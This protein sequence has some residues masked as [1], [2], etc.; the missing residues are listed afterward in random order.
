MSSILSHFPAP[1]FAVFTPYFPEATSL[2]PLLLDLFFAL[3]A[4]PG[5]AK[6]LDSTSLPVAGQVLPT[7]EKLSRQA[8][9]P[10][11]GNYFDDLPSISSEP[12]SWAATLH[13]EPSCGAKTTDSNVQDAFLAPFARIPNLFGINVVDKS[14]TL[15]EASTGPEAVVGRD[16]E[17][18]PLPFLPAAAGVA[19]NY[20]AAAIRIGPE[21]W[22]LSFPV[23]ASVLCLM[24][25]RN[26]TKHASQDLE[27]ALHEQYADHDLSWCLDS[28]QTFRLPKGPREGWWVRQFLKEYWSCHGE[29]VAFRILDVG[30]DPSTIMAWLTLWIGFRVDNKNAALTCGGAPKVW[31]QS[32]GPQ[33]FPGL[34]IVFQVFQH[35]RL[36]SLKT[37][38]SLGQGGTTSCYSNS[39]VNTR[40]RSRVE[41]LT[42][43]SYT[44]NATNLFRKTQWVSFGI[45]ASGVAASV[46][47]SSPTNTASARVHGASLSVTSAAS[48]KSRP[49]THSAPSLAV[50]DFYSHI[51]F[52]PTTFEQGQDGAASDSSYDFTLMGTR[53]LGANE[54]VV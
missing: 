20:T 23:I 32:E 38:Q 29:G 8:G 10:I 15:R 46:P 43:T 18:G 27:P 28:M 9:I 45:S 2:C 48:S 49:L 42:P 19:R 34:P 16:G 41:P 1:T 33:C 3:G 25:N 30:S 52:P 47:A 11:P 14:S 21:S 39:S 44:F 5:D 37:S 51:I 50:F 35:S 40:A 4:E 12:S 54:L 22:A 24:T 7:E 26:K 36:L 6:P 53:V 17:S 31:Q 13:F